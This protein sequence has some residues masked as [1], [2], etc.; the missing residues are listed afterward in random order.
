MKIGILTFHCAHNYGAVLQCYALQET[1]KDMGFDV[2]VI[3]YR[4]FFIRYDK[5][6]NIKNIRNRRGIINKIKYLLKGI[7]KIPKQVLRYNA[8][9]KF[10]RKRLLLSEHNNDYSFIPDKYDVYIIGSDQVW[11]NRITNGYHLP[12]FAHFNFV[13]GNRKYI[14]YAASMET[15][16]IND[17]SIKDLLLQFNHISVRETNLVD[18]L[19]PYY[20]KKIYNVLDPTLIVNLNIWNKICVKPKYS[21][22]YVLVYQA[23]TENYTKHIANEIAKQLNVSVIEIYSYVDY[24]NKKNSFQCA[25]PEEFLGWFKFAE[26]II[27]TSFHGTAFS[28]IFNK[29]FYTIELNSDWNSRTYSLLNLLKLESRI[30]KNNQSPQFCKINYIEVNNKLNNLKDESKSFLYNSIKY[31]S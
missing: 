6:I 28:I 12:Y 5:Y 22:K 1:L 4:P 14:S 27:T 3:D 18:I 24:L 15:N 25:T 19:Q 16:K 8:F 30:I 31:D 10:I 20:P 11:N 21:N 23:I 26:C 9:D 29:P 7:I 17:E 2:E 13:K